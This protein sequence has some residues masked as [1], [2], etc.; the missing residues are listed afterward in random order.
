MF[1]AAFVSS[2]G[3]GRNCFSEP[4][5]GQGKSGSRRGDPLSDD[6]NV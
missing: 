4:E 6:Q 1:N 5:S 3:E 2:P